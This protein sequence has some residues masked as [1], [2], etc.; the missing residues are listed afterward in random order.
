MN[1]V[2]K[3]LMEHYQLTDEK[4]EEVLKEQTIKFKELYSTLPDEVLKI[5][6]LNSM[7]SRLLRDKSSGRTEDDVIFFG[8]IE[9]TGFNRIRNA[10]YKK[11][12][13][14]TD[15]FKKA[16]AQKLIN[17]EGTL[18]DKWGNE[19]DTDNISKGDIHTLMGY[20][21]KD[22]LILGNIQDS[23]KNEIVF[24]KPCHVVFTNSKAKSPIQNI[25]IKNIDTIT[26]LESITPIKDMPSHIESMYMK[27]LTKEIPIINKV[28]EIKGCLYKYVALQGIISKI[29]DS[30][31]GTAVELSTEDS[32]WKYILKLNIS[33]RIKNFLI[34]FVNED[35]MVKVIAKVQQVD[36]NDFTIKL[37]A[38]TLWCQ[39]EDIL[40]RKEINVEIKEESKE[41]TKS[42]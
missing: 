3:V 32:D 15:G 35:L 9:P 4:W 16:L 19:I 13:K 27:Y 1:D 7:R 12:M 40:E 42:W 24:G 11:I 34:N 5:K 18:I 26:P 41:G 8:Y 39:P 6:I 38:I 21:E 20:N 14:E 2:K 31:F 30:S 36:E 28:D 10:T 29:Y 33:N 23:K 25:E 17:T 22:D 37:S